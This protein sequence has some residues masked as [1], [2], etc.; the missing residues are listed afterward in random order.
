MLDHC[1][2]ARELP[3]TGDIFVVDDLRHRVLVIDRQSK[4]IIWQYVVTDRKG[5]QPG[6][7]FYPDGFDIDVFRD[8]KTALGKR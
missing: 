7:L 6:Y 3:D 5:H 2:I 1:S 8:W 4:E